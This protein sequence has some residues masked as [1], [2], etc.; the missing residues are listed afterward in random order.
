M[1]HNESGGQHALRPVRATDQA[2]AG[3]NKRSA[4]GVCDKSAATRAA[5]PAFEE[6]KPAAMYWTRSARVRPTAAM[7]P[8]IPAGAVTL[9]ASELKLLVSLLSAT[10]FQLSA[11]PRACAAR[12][13]GPPWR[14]RRRVCDAPPP[15]D[16]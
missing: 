2:C 9:K 14:S 12:R 1:G 4:L 3:A 15:A 11:A 16:W 6:P 8:A 13:S 10:W 7:L 5:A